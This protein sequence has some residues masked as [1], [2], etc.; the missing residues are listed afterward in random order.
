MNEQPEAKPKNETDNEAPKRGQGFIDGRG[1]ELSETQ[2][3]L[4]RLIIV[5]AV[6][7]GLTIYAYG[8]TVTD[9]NLDRPQEEQR[10]E[11]VTR[12]LRELLSPRLFTQDRELI[13]LEAPV[14]LVEDQAA[15]SDAAV[16][17]Q[18]ESDD[19]TDGTVVVEP[20]CVTASDTVTVQVSGSSP[21]ADARVRWIPPV[22]GGQEPRPRPREV[23]ETEREDIVLNS[24]GD[25]TGTIEVPRI[26]GGE[27][28]VHT[29]EVRVAVPSGPIELS[30]TSQQVLERIAETIFMALVATTIAIPIAA[31][32]SFFAARNLMR[33]MRMSLGGVLLAFI[34]F[35]IGIAI[36]GELLGPLGDAA[37]QLGQ[38][39]FD[40]A[41]DYAITLAI[42][43]V[44]SL[45]GVLVMIWLPPSD[46][47]RNDA[48][49][50]SR[51]RILLNTLVRVLKPI[52]LI[53]IL[54][55]IVGL[56]GGL[57]ML[58]GAA[59][60][61]AGESLQ[62]D[63]AN[64]IGARLAN[65]VGILAAALGRLLE[66]FGTLLGML[67]RGVG[68][69]LFGVALATIA[70]DLF[71]ARLRHT[72]LVLN[73]VLGGLLGAV[74][75]GL[76]MVVMALAA[77][78]ASL[79]GVL[80]LLVAA[81]LGGTLLQI[82][83]SKSLDVAGLPH[84][85]K[86]TDN[87]TSHGRV[88]GWALFGVGAVVAGLFTISQ[89]NIVQNIINGTLPQQ[90]QAVL[91]GYT[92]SITSYEFDSIVIGAVLAGIAGALIGVRAVF[93]LGNTMYNV[94]RVSL[95][96]VR[97]IEPLIMGLV[98]VIW[99]GIGPFAG[100]LALTL[101]S[102]AALGKLYSEQ[103]EN[104]DNGPLEALR[105][106]GASHLQTITYA[107]VPQIIP[108]YIAFTMYRWD[109]NVRMSTIIGF[110]G[111]GGIGLLLQ[112]QINL[113]RYRDAGV[114]VL[115]IAIVVSILDYAS[116]MIRE[117]VM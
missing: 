40:K 19:Q 98:F 10:Q 63:S 78:W 6:A 96:I 50:T 112:Q 59:V 47:D 71:G 67:I 97:S 5:L 48:A 64:N 21:N 73:H 111:G 108:P 45:V 17:A 8:W 39:H 56:V 33:Q 38:G 9:I 54:V 77:L 87:R 34:S 30:E 60:I 46:A 88:T 72:P 95:N 61:E 106:T 58:G 103:I 16:P 109:I 89:L 92:L 69:L 82:M 37:I 11:N 24:N 105:A 44:L 18:P 75:G 101:H 80:P 55:F 42:F 57:A 83:V 32:L 1:G 36:G 26:R 35:T 93:P 79:L 74:G 113:L 7:L 49:M 91:F 81:V 116:A 86:Y 62:P 4:L 53:V 110:V 43:G 27:G 12:A 29:V 14:L 100:V 31:V 68:A 107:V 99:V 76:F 23:L 102:I 52:L 28:E 115:A 94:A 117:R 13:S 65:I 15:C 70:G 22:Q 104:I 84:L 85:K 66:I 2:K 3:A 25:F 51:W 20:S 41:A 114:A 90:D